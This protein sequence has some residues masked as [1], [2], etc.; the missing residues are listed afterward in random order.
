[1]DVYGFANRYLEGYVI[2]GSEIVSDCPYCH[3]GQH[4]DKRTFALNMD[5]QTFNCKRGSCGK[6]GTFQQLCKDFKEE[7]DSFREWKQNN[8]Y[9]RVKAQDKVYKKPGTVLKP[10]TDEAIDYLKKRGFTEP[11]WLNRGLKCDS[12]GNIAMPYKDDKDQAVMLKFRPSHKIKPEEMKSWREAGGKPI[13]WGMDKCSYE[14]PLVI[15]EGEMDAMA[16]DEAGIKNV[17]SV[18]SGA[19]DLTWID[20]CWEWLQGFKKIII[21]GDTDEPGQKMVN[22]VIKRLGEYRC[23]TV[24][25]NRK[26]ANET[27]F[28]DGKDKVLELFNGAAEVP[29]AGL[30][31][32]ADVERFDYSKIEKTISNIK[33]LDKILGGFMA[34][35]TTIWTGSNG[36]GKSTF[37]GQMLI[38][39]IDQGF[40]VCAFSGELPAPYFANWIELQMAGPN[41]ITMVDDRTYQEKMPSIKKPI[42]EQMR[43]WYKDKFFLYD[44]STSNKADDILKVFEYAAQ[45]YN[46][47]TF[48]IDNLMMTDFYDGTDYYRAQSK[49]IGQVVEFAHKFNVHVHLVAHPRKVNGMIEKMDIAGSGDITNRAD[50]V[51]GITRLSDVKELEANTALIGMGADVRLDIMKNR[52]T[53]RQN[54]HLGLKYDNVSKRFYETNGSPNKAYKW[55]MEIQGSFI[56]VNDEGCPF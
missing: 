21:W 47:K 3:G 2:K 6:A 31:R 18:P 1:M 7:A 29:F 49:F 52:F 34:G 33:P 28:I 25:G 15:V 38:E 30:L 10:L 11:T 24:Q 9:E 14:K 40:N 36:S 48:L 26:D 43:A 27:L 50:N 45:R 17:T 55:E 44:N 37:L 13:L 35:Q 41:N 8:N 39:S 16:L 32:L 4:H 23:Y 42:R 51:I 5:K 54:K 12:K 19:E 56:E 20:N 53:G 22:A 46:C